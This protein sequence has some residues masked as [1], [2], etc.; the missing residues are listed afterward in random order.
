KRLMGFLTTGGILGSIL[1][2]LLVG[3]LSQT[4]LAGGLLPL[5]CIMLLG[6]G[7][8][9]RGVFKV[10]QEGTA[11]AG[12]PPA[13][14]TGP[15]KA[16]ASFRASFDA[17]RKNRLLASIAGIVALGV[18]VS[19]CV[20]FQFLSAA[21]G[22]YFGSG[23]ALRVALQTFFGF[24]DPALTLFVLFLNI[25]V[26]GFLF[27]KLK[28]FGTLLF[29]PAVL[30]AASAAVLCLPFGL[31]IGILIRGADEGTSFAVNQSA[32]ELLYIPVPARL[33]HRAKPFIDMF[34][35]QSAK[36]A[37]A[38]VLYLFAVALHKEIKGFTPV[39]DSNLA[40][41]LSWVVIVL[42]I[43]WAVLS[44]RAGRAYLDAIG[45]NIH[46]L[47]PRAEKELAEKL[48]VGRAKLVFDTIDSRNHSSVLYALH[49]FDLLAEDQLT[50]DVKEALA[51]KS[52]EVRAA[53]VADRFEAEG[54][55]QLLT[56][57]DDMPAEEVL[58]EIPLIMSSAQYQEVM[59]AYFDKVRGELPGAEVKRME[60]AKA[61]GFM[62]PDSRLASRLPELIDDGSSQVSRI[63]MRSAA[64]LKREDAL[65]AII[66]RLENVLTEPDAA[67]ALQ[68]YGDR[69][70]SA[71]AGSLQDRARGP[72]LRRAAVEVLGKIGTPTAGL[73]LADELADGPGD[74][75][76]AVIDALDRLRSEHEEVSVPPDTVGRKTL[77]LAQAYCRTYLEL[78]VLGRG[79]GAED[80]RQR[81]EGSLRATLADIFK[82]LGLSYPQKDIRTVYQN[83]ST[84]RRHAVGHA[85]EW[86]D[87][88]L[89]KDIR[90]LVL[91][92]VEDLEPEEKARRLEKVLRT[93]SQ[94]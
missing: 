29:T 15:E 83:I 73:A 57:L 64:R 75:D 45:D 94:H 47:W 85:V 91:P 87:N 38:V 23:R 63:A 78:Q 43:P 48:D 49:L 27:K 51:E 33:R 62:G 9:S 16:E 93:L 28:S 53:A 54:T 24:F 39:F 11:A 31:L 12:W 1:G 13:R 86:L 68:K 81:L 8:I 67:D 34:V 4:A 36:V 7:L 92:L 25:A 71:L 41:E 79:A 90:D 32:R 2:G 20:E 42:L 89:K 61:I 22:H 44:Y 55:P 21:Y 88:V 70:A 77:E 82:L 5:A 26:A 52:A 50:P 3:F 59:E 65:P 6:C 46:P 14:E 56:V 58:T 17:V 10:P 19:T 40:R 35:S 74:L 30:V 84:G 72:A 18:I 60:L 37:G 66:R 76:P 69:A 80:A